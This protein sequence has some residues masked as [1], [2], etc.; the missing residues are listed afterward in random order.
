M[1]QIAPESPLKKLPNSITALLT[2]YELTTRDNCL[3]YEKQALRF[4]AFTC[5][6]RDTLSKRIQEDLAAR[7]NQI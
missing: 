1:T 4:M 7:N 6:N 5:R 3:N 2:F